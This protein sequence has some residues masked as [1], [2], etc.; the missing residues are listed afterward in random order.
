MSI[1]PTWGKFARR[2]MWAAWRNKA[3]NLP[4]LSCLQWL[5]F[6]HG[7]M[8][9]TERKVGAVT[10]RL[11]QRGWLT[12]V[13][14]IGKKHYGDF[15]PRLDQPSEWGGVSWAFRPWGKL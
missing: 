13:E 8:Q 7:A 14:Y 3:R 1:H 10:I 2:F 15:G 9:V 5:H 6:P 11:R 4:F 12:E